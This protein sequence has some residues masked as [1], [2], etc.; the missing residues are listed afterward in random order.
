[1]LATQK[2][3]ECNRELSMQVVMEYIS[4]GKTTIVCPRCHS[5]P[6]VELSYTPNTKRLERTECY[7]RCGYISYCAMGITYSS[8]P[9]DKSF[10][11]G[12]RKVSSE[13]LSPSE[14][15]SVKEAASSIDVPLDVLVFNDLIALRGPNGTHYNYED[16]KIYITQNIFPDLTSNSTHPRDLLSVRAVLAHEY[17]GHRPN[18]QEYLSDK[19]KGV[20]TLSYWEDE[21]RASITAAKFTP[22]LSQMEKAMLIQDAAYRAR[23]NSQVLELDDYMKNILYG[24]GSAKPIALPLV[25]KPVEEVR[26]AL[27]SSLR[28]AYP[29]RY[30][31]CDYIPDVYYEGYR[32]EAYV[33]EIVIFNPDGTEIKSITDPDIVDSINSE[34]D[35]QDYLEDYVDKLSRDYDDRS[36]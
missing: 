5:F 14:I 2:A 18:R 9:D 29:D 19:E 25:Y 8:M 28:Q 12:F 31:N 35:L 6:I 32:A 23:E 10:A 36:L 11:M 34:A 27:D 16:D 3:S 13:P 22:N 4:S 30:D 21:T 26:M 20:H 15:E 17:Y 1:M 24:D 33:E 7:C